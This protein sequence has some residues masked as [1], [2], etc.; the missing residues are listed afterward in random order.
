[1]LAPQRK[2]EIIRM[3][4]EQ[5]FVEVSDLSKRFDVSEV[6]IRSDLRE[7]EQTGKIERKYGGAV[8]KEC[9]ILPFPH[10]NQLLRERKS[11]IAAAAAALIQSGDSVFL[12]SSTTAWFLAMQMR[13]L[14]DI[15]IISNSIPVFEL[16][17][18]YTE[19]NLI[20]IPGVLNPTT[21]SFVGPIAEELI[22]RL[23]C[24]KAFI[25]PKGILP[26]GLREN[27]I[28]EASVRKA[29]I[30]A[31]SET[32]LLA[33]HSKFLNNRTLF[34]IDDFRSIR[35]VVTD[36]TPPREF[37]ELFERRDI[38]LIVTEG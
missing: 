20:A 19:G 14:Q 4:E 17:K 1:M 28:M 9:D 15:T 11:A 32:I 21:Q 18:E 30:D 8:L 6:T 5:G 25:S 37:L 36:Q 38:R 35:T 12:D 13:K 24:S 22:R 16:F 26:Q 7:L 10:S 27:S 34:G 33:D 23:H 31:S 2:K 3:V 29:M